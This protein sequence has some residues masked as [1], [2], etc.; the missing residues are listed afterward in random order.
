MSAPAGMPAPRPRI[1]LIHA[2]TVAIDPVAQAFA[3]LWPEAACFNLLDDSLGPDR[4]RDEGMT[5]GM[6]KRIGDLTD[7][8]ASTSADGILFT[9]SAFG[10]AIE[11]AAGRVVIPVRLIVR[12]STG[13]VRR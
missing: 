11:Q 8:A 3:R 12:G 1:A 9:C 4:E 5:A 10:A 2:V 13:E 7:Y 6:T